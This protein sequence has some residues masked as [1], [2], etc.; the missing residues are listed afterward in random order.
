LKP[1]A[2]GVGYYGK[3]FESGAEVAFRGSGGGLEG[4]FWEAIGIE[5]G[6]Y[7][8][9]RGC[10]ENPGLYR[11]VFDLVEGEA[12]AVGGGVAWFCDGVQMAGGDAGFEDQIS[13]GL[14]DAV[15][16]VDDGQG[17]EATV[18][19]SRSHVDV[20]SPGVAGV[21]GQLQEGVLHVGDAGRSPPGSFH[22]GQ[23]GE[24]GAEVPVWAFH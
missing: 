11:V 12:C 7:G 24:A 9:R 6:L 5:G 4:T 23:A 3:A 10:G 13:V 19:E 16:V 17:S 22:A 21:A 1:W 20:G 8:G 14:W 15:A 18:F 2:L